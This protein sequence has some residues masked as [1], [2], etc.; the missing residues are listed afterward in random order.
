MEAVTPDLAA[1]APASLEDLVDIEAI[2][3]VKY[4][5]FRLLDSKQFDQLGLLLTDDVTTS[6]ESGTYSHNGPEEV[7]SFL[8]TSL[9][10]TGIVHE[11]LGH[12]PEISL[13]GEGTAVGY[14][15]L[16]DRVVVPAL[17]FELGGTAIYRDEYRKVNGTWKI[18]HTGYDRVYE[19]H[20]KLSTGEVTSFRSRF[21]ADKS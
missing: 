3:A 11:H 2:K 9:G 12:H 6:Y 14:W 18:S 8:S 20:K 5:Y 19:E 21:D 17:D 1:P 15:Y 10:D 13:A 7:V 16:H 4:A